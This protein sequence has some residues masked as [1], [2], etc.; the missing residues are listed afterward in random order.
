M[1]ELDDGLDFSNAAENPELLAAAQ[2]LTD[3]RK[4]PTLENP[5]DGPVTLPGGFRRVKPGSDGAEFEVVR[6]AWVR[7]LN[8]DDE[9]RIARAKMKQ[10]V[11]AFIRAILECGVDRL[12]DSRPT[13]E[14][15]DSLLVGDQQFLLVEIARATY[16]DEVEYNQFGCPHCGKTFDFSLS[17]SDDIP[18]KRLDR[19][20]DAT[21]DIRLRKDR[22]A[23]VTLPTGEV[24]ALMAETDTAAE[25]NTVLITNCVEEIR[26]PQGT[27]Q[28]RGQEDVA[29]RLGVADRQTLVNGLSERMPGP[30]Y[31]EVR[32]KHDPGC[33]EEI[34]L[35]VTLADLFLGL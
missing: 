35:S 11:S 5:L 26:G 16:G 24:A 23:T 19:S 4:P 29:R 6:S 30:Q 22:V 12:G 8:G 1:T 21:F 27:V 2:A 28:V 3:D 17:I 25:A 10:D 13:R 32:F 9:E 31:N 20:T 7:E 18:V 15:L 33:G 14:D 34:R